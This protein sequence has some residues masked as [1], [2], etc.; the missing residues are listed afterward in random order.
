MERSVKVIIHDTSIYPSLR[1]IDSPIQVRATISHCNSFIA[2]VSA[3]EFSISERK[4]MDFK[5]YKFWLNAGE[6]TILK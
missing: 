6:A 3:T 5:S 1:H 2:S 4:P